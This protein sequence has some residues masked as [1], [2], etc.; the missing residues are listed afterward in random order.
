MGTK[1]NK[2]TF[3]NS[4]L[5]LIALKSITI[6][7]TFATKWWLKDSFND[8]VMAL[9]IITVLFLRTFERG[10]NI[11]TPFFSISGKDD[12]NE[13]DKEENNI[14]KEIKDK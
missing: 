5:R 6:Y 3:I 1:M 12:N 9:I 7:L 13:N 10:V 4:S 2:L 11:K 14:K 8:W